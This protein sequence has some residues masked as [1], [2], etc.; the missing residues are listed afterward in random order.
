V[1]YGRIGTD[2]Q[3]NVKSFADET[4]AAKQAEKLVKEKTGNGYREVQ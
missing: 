1:R 3:T 4:G 2:G